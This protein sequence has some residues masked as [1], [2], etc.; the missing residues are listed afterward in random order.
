[1]WAEPATWSPSVTPYTPPG[2]LIH[3]YTH[4][5][6]Q[7]TH[8][9]NQIKTFKVFFIRLHFEGISDKNTELG[10]QDLHT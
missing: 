4:A 9:L 7:W 6:T 2:D 5:Q 10:S 8:K 1:M 3:T